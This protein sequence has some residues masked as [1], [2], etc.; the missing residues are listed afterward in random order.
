MHARFFAL[1]QPSLK[2]LQRNTFRQGVFTLG[3]SIAF[4]TRFYRQFS[5]RDSCCIRTIPR[6]FHA[7]TI[8]IP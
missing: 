4:Q 7:T 6:S 3:D 2:Q 5:R 8:D 1:F